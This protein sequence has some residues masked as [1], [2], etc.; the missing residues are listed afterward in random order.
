M[1]QLAQCAAQ[2]AACCADSGGKV[3]ALEAR[4]GDRGNFPAMAGQKGVDNLL[5]LWY[6]NIAPKGDAIAFHW[7]RAGRLAG[8]LSFARLSAP[9]RFG[10][11][12]PPEVRSRPT[13]RAGGGASSGCHTLPVRVPPSVVVSAP[14]PLGEKRKQKR[15][16]RKDGAVV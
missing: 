2:G 12:R 7:K 6:Y 5:L 9:C 15:L 14:C 8:P 13:G 4:R 10:L 1:V 16:D 3:A 11:L